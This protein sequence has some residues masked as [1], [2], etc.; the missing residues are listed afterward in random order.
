MKLLMLT[1]L[2]TL[3]LADEPQYPV[4]II[5]RQQHWPTLYGENFA[6]TCYGCRTKRS[7]E[8]NPEAQ[9]L[10]TVPLI[11]HP[12][13]PNAQVPKSALP[14]PPAALPVVP[15]YLH[16]VHT[17]ASALDLKNSVPV[18][19]GAP[20]PKYPGVVV[21]KIPAGPVFPKVP[22]VPVAPIAPAAPVISAVPL[23]AYP[24]VLPVAPAAPVV[25][26]PEEVTPVKVGAAVHPEGVLGHVERSPQGF[27]DFTTLNLAGTHIPVLSSEVPEAPEAKVVPAVPLPAYPA[28]LPAAPVIPAVHVPA[29]P[30]VVPAA[31]V[32]PAVVTPEEVT[33]V[34][35]GAA[36]HPEG[37]LGHVERSPQGLSDFTTL[38]LAGTHIPVLSAGLPVEA[39]E[40]PA[41]PAE[42][43]RKRSAQNDFYENF[44]ALHGEYPKAFVTGPGIYGVGN[45]GI[46]TVYDVRS[47]PM[48]AIGR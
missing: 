42:T 9:F 7:A 27:S 4:P 45:S 46:S 47:S 5:P 1:T 19:V 29:H 22:A 39:P 12:L 24:A 44:F 2:A 34:K 6:S 37:V 18:P 21:P 15:T 43:R 32:A 17:V 48:G 14:A 8:A 30:V 20:A 10:A 36:V 26:T 33:P 11:H 13:S 35:V 16:G 40:A 38:N 31:P 25:V 41:A 28:V 23:P 3:A